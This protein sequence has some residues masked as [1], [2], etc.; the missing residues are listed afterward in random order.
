MHKSYP[1]FHIPMDVPLEIPAHLVDKLMDDPRLRQ[2]VSAKLVTKDAIVSGVPVKAGKAYIRR[3]GVDSK[4]LMRVLLE[5]RVPVAVEIERFIKYIG[6]EMDKAF[7]EKFDQEARN[8]MHRLWTGIDEDAPPDVK[9]K[10]P[11]VIGVS[12]GDNTNTFADLK[13]LFL[14]IKKK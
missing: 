6:R 8:W 14:N 4:T 10:Y 5:H 11:P 9:V 1:P 13:K 12:T 3:M 7:Q 2:G